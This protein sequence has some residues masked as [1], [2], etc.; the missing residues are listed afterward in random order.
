MSEPTGGTT[1]GTTEPTQWDSTAHGPVRAPAHGPVHASYSPAP[2]HDRT[3]MPLL[4]MITRQSLDED[5]QHVA[6]HRVQEAAPV[7]RSR[8]ALTMAVVLLFG[9][10]VAVAA[11]QTSRNAP[12]DTESKDQLISRINTRRAAVADLQKQIGSLRASTTRDDARYGDLGHRLS[13]TTATQHALLA[14]TG[15]GPMSGDGVRAV[16]DDA[17]SGSDGQVR[18]SDL[19]ALVNGL[20]QAGARAISVNG[21]RVTV[22]SSLRNS[23]TVVRIND[24]SLS[25]PYT[26]LALGNVDTLQARFAQSTSGIRLGSLTRQ[27]GMGF[28]MHNERGLTLPSAPSSML[29]LLHARADA[30][31]TNEKEKP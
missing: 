19:A 25:P 4:E 23:G 18:D 14:E 6:E 26:V 13:Q 15:W 5:Y 21:Q 2:G 10:L 30:R 16:L 29:V 31:P 11:V 8:T 7:N 20:W 22:L 24:F 3:V 17:P 27:F 28:T 1:G 9:L 12:I